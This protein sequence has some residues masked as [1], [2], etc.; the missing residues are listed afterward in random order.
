MLFMVVVGLRRFIRTLAVLSAICERCGNPAAHRLVRRTRCV[1]LLFVPVFPVS[2]SWGMTCTYCGQ[3]TALTSARVGELLAGAAP[4]P[5]P[6]VVHAHP[7]R[8]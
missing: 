6:Q 3:G 4:R 2:R 7:R 8:P 5:V 1:V